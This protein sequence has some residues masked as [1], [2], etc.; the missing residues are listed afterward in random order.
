MTKSSKDKDIF[1][2]T[3]NEWKCASSEKTNYFIHLWIQEDSKPII[4]EY[5]EL[6]L[7]VLRFQEIS[8]EGEQWESIKINY[9]VK[10]N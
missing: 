9:S 6:K 3:K 4:I 7:R 1:F 5:E 2:L 10:T 8:N